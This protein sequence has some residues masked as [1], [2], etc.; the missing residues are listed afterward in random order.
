MFYLAESSM[1]F[2]FVVVVLFDSLSD[3]AAGRPDC[4]GA[5]LGHCGDTVRMSGRG[6]QWCW[7]WRGGLRS[8]GD[9]AH[10]PGRAGSGAAQGPA[11]SYCDHLL[12]PLSHLLSLALQHSIRFFLHLTLMARRCPQRWR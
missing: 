11:P 1:S 7:G 12:A 8:L 5:M 4:T 6:C 9:G 10:P 3:T 2:F